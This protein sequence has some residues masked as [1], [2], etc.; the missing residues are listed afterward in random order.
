MTDPVVSP[1]TRRFHRDI[2]VCLSYIN[3]ALTHRPD[4]LDATECF[5]ETPTW[6]QASV[7]QLRDGGV[8]VAVFSHGLAQ[9][10]LFPGLEAVRYMLRSLD[11]MVDAAERTPGT[12]IL[13]SATDL[14]AALA[15]HEVA[16]LLHLIGL[17][18]DNDFAI[19]RTYHRVGVRM[20]HIFSGDPRVGGEPDFSAPEVGLGE[21]GREAIRV[22]E[23]IGMIVDVA[24]TNDRTFDDVLATVTRPVVDTHTVCR[25]ITPIGRACTDEQLRAIAATGGVIGVHFA[26]GFVYPE[27]DPAWVAARREAVIAMRE[28][29]AEMERD[30][31]DNPYEFLCHRWDPEEW[32]RSLGGAIDDGIPVPNA[33]LDALLR[34]IDH[35]V[36]VAGIDHVGIGP[37]Y[38]N[39]ANVVGLETAASMPLLTQ[40]LLDHGYHRDEVAAIMGRN[41]V[42]FLRRNLPA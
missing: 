18:I 9:S 12:R 39:A 5:N 7:P 1:E 40:A 10:E 29:I 15:A 26:A 3:P 19:F 31:A 17:P 32:P 11:A 13:R 22:M 21:L 23:R 36:E 4:G 35:M 2:P 30:Y 6:S 33:P 37:D 41:W 24:H 20:A 34:Q 28:R 27:T 42:D 25:A 16:I 38:F 8:D 14:D